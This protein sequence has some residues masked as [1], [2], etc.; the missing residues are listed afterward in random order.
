MDGPQGKRDGDDV[1]LAPDPL[2]V[3]PGVMDVSRDALEGFR[4][5]RL[6][7]PGQAFAFQPPVAP[8]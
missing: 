8:L 7:A 6:Q 4:V 3:E 2:D 5:G 1:T